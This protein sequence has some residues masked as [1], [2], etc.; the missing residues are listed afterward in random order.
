MKI[1]ALTAGA[2]RMYCG[3]C[4]RDNM[5][6][7]ALKRLGH[8]VVLLPLYT[9]TRTDDRN[10]SEPR[11]FLNGISVCLDQEAA[12]FRKEHRWLD[13]LWDSPWMLRLASRTSIRV[14][15]HKLGEM[16]VSMLR[17]EDGYQLKEIRR[18]TDW[19]RSEAPPDIV[20]LPNSLLIG[21]ARPIR[22]AL[23]RPVC[24]TL[25][26]EELFLDQLPEPYRAAA[27]D[28]IRSKTVD[29]DGFTA[30]SEAGARFW[31]REMGIPEK[32]M[33]V[34]PL[35]VNLE[36]FDAS[37]RIRSERF[38][39]GFLARIAPEKGLHTLAEAYIRLRRDSAL[40]AASLRTAG[41][42]APEHKDYLQKVKRLMRDA[43]LER[44]FCYDGA[45]DRARKIEFLR[46]VDVFSVPCTYDEPKGI[47]LL[48]A[49]AVGTPVVQPPRG[50]FPEIIQAT[51]GGILARAGDAESLADAIRRLWT[52][53]GL[54]SDLGSKG[55][56]GVREHYGASR[57]AAR[58]LDA[59]VAV[60]A[61]YDHA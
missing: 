40:G 3:S 5:L 54:A 8:D 23:R 32:K 61:A 4:L 45:P 51:G 59:Y 10:V 44:E 18:L 36:G 9:P 7:A 26:G 35:G 19:L 33:R 21:L 22:D 34:V 56:A 13:R 52:T 6:A 50:S 47:S 46:G 38:T 55:A 14:D 57:M 25:Q 29:V 43:G 49:M 48:E 2:A 53:P 11:V 58:A 60:A 20:T 37:P 24:C 12:F 27:R 39:L 16:T 15:P 31:V 42:L 41:Y 1:L 28:L 17:G 30:V